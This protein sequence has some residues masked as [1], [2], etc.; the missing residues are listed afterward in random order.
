MCFVHCKTLTRRTIYALVSQPVVG[1]WG[2]APRLLP[3]LY[4]W[5]P[6]G[7]FRPQTP[8]LPT[9]GKKILWAPMCYVD[10]FLQSF[11][12]TQRYSLKQCAKYD[13]CSCFVTHLN[14][15]DVCVCSRSYRRQCVVTWTASV[16]YLSTA[17]DCT[18]TVLLTLTCRTAASAR[19]N[20]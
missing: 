18:I 5:T 10:I 11:V 6:L 7:D 14:C 2:F 9:P 13:F 16:I 8:N 3:G 17:T 15:H 12:I 1:F 19:L 4:P 20:R